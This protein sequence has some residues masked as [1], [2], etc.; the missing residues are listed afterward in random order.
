MQLP[1]RRSLSV[2]SKI[3]TAACCLLSVLN[4]D[5]ANGQNSL[6]VTLANPN[7]STI[8]SD[9]L[10]MPAWSGSAS[11]GS[12]F[13]RGINGVAHQSTP[14]LTH[15]DFQYSAWYR[16][17]GDQEC[18]ILGRRNLND[19][20]SGWS[21]FNTRLEFIHGDA[22]D[23]ESGAQTQPWDNHNAINMGIS[24]DGRVHLSFDHHGN[25]FNY[26]QGD[27]TATTWSRTGVF[28]VNSKAAMQAL[29][30]NSLDGGPPVEAVTYPRFS[31]N[32]TTGEMVMTVRLGESG[33]GDLF[34]AN[35][36]LTTGT[37][38][39][40]RE[41]IRGD[42][43]VVFN[44]R[45]AAT[46]NS[47]NPYLN[48]ITYSSDGDLHASFTWR[49]TANGT[50]N[51]DLNYIRSTDGGLTWLN[52]SDDNV[53]ELVSILSPGIII[54]S[55]SDFIT[56]FIGNGLDGEADLID[57]FSG[58]LSNWTS[59]VILDAQNAGSNTSTFRINS[60]GQLE[61]ATT[62]YNG[63]EQYAFIYDGLSLEVGEE[64][65]LDVPI[66]V[67][68]NRNLGLYVGGTAPVTGVLGTEARQDYIAVY[69]GTNSRV[70]TRGFDGTGEY[71]NVELIALGASSLF[72]AQ[73]DEN[74]FEVGF[75]TAEDVRVVVA[76]RTPDF[77][78]A[79][80][81]VGIYADAREQGTLGTADNFRIQSLAD[82]PSVDD[83]PLGLIDREQT[84]MNQQGQT[85]DS[86]GG[87]HV[88]MWSRADPSTRDPSDRAFDTTEAAHAHYFK[89]PVTGEW[90]KNQ[91]PVIDEDG[92][93]AQVGTRGQIAYD[94][95]GNVFAAYTTP[96]V[97]EDDNRNF[98]DPGTLI[99]AGATADS[100][101]ADW[102][103]LYRDDMF[104]NRF[105]EGE[106]L[107]DQQ[108]LASEGVLSVFVQEGSSNLGVTASDLHVLDFNVVSPSSAL[109]GDFD[110][111]GDVDADDI[112][113]Y[114]G[115]LDLAATGDFAQLD[116]D[117]DQFVTLADHDLHVT[118]LVQID[119]VQTGTLIGDINLDG[120]VDVL[121]DAFALV[122][123]LGTSSGGYANGD[124]DANSIID[125]LGDA[126]T[127]ISNLGQSIDSQ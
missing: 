38:S 20:A 64:V 42:D 106:P 12:L 24:G 54:D 50:A 43:G 40:L 23:P 97:A 81:F 58:D 17:T 91:I 113:F 28:G 122:G 34:I 10:L 66:P 98:Y 35:Y 6:S 33:A 14:L 80:T 112:D 60:N 36:D 52:D 21:T 76:V 4:T 5:S 109:A 85:V 11:G 45:I 101:Y 126:F 121:N 65:R 55:T 2:R 30:Q 78:N 118:T 116:L 70:A 56:P 69:S 32:P 125:V 1:Q 25:Q 86:N 53:G 8:D 100:G 71:N 62:N 103:I 123:S 49:E 115:N 47:R 95:N 108:R 77:L 46:S 57:D 18:I 74:R 90:T 83:S 89:D 51:H 88:L 9:A 31:T 59:T 37:W 39:E 29:T 94:S 15:G 114:S 111:D 104:F 110:M 96:G 75:Y 72:I 48:D 120:S 124:L 19:L 27:A 119:N 117:G 67:L 73:T 7:S 93:N 79:A 3:F 92:N 61:L 22:I 84:L 41:F 99:I 102:S 26:V 82:S 44:D 127:L 107:I 87:V 16:N 68:G 105:F 13:G 63:I